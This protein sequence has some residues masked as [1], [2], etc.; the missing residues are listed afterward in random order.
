MCAEHR[1]FIQCIEW[2]VSWTNEEPG[3]DW[4]KDKNFPFFIQLPV[5]WLPE[6]VVTNWI[7]IA[8]YEEGNTRSLLVG[9]IHPFKHIPVSS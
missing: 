6:P 1:Q 9:T 4:L 7:L 2:A 3:F 8:K 5:C